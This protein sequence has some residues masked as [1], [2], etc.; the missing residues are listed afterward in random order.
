[1]KKYLG[2]DLGTSALKALVCNENNEVLF[3][4]EE[5]YPLE[6]P[7]PLYSEQNPAKWL[8]ALNK[9]FTALNG[10]IDS[11][12]ALSFSGQMHG[13]VV[14]D[15]NDQIIRPCI[16]WNDGRA[17]AETDYLNHTFGQEKLAAIT[18]NMA[19]AGFTL[20]KLLW[21]A[22]NEPENYRKIAKI[23]LPKDYLVYMLTKKFVTDY[24]DAA[25]TLLLDGKEKVWSQTLISLAGLQNDN[26]PQ[27]LESYESVGKVSASYKEKFPFLGSTEVI[28]GGADNAVAAI[29]TGTVAE[30]DLNISLGTSGTVLLP[31]KNFSLPAK[32]S[33]H[34]FCHANG[35]YYWMGCILSAAS[36]RKWWLE[37]ILATNDYAQDEKLL[38]QA[39]LNNLYFLPYLAGE[40]SPHN[41]VLAEGAFIGLTSTTSRQE[42]SLAVIEGVSFALKDSLEI[43]KANNIEIKNVTLCGGGSKSKVWCQKLANILGVEIK[44]L[45]NEQGPS[46]GAVFLAMLGSK[47]V[48]SFSTLKERFVKVLKTYIPEPEEV[49]YYS[50]KYRNFTKL[51]PLL[52]DFFHTKIIEN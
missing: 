41:D 33:L 45:E 22:K 25:G 18:G 40:R 3:T 46:Q 29:G 21:L 8:E 10:Q 13:L 32:N 14:L 36:A 19:Y 15:K 27:L 1:M 2:I 30:G 31:M 26:L 34:A 48:A 44:V 12:T 16:L 42:M 52:K 23:M 4:F 38:A 20:P 49:S 17:Q 47:G 7:K 39:K 37:K 50:E 35:H 43:A 6:N 9:V 11:L 24:S 5:A 28:I 51:Y